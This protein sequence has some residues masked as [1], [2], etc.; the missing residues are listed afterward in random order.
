MNRL[1][2]LVLAFGLCSFLG[3]GMACL[4]P[5]NLPQERSQSDSEVCIPGVVFERKRPDFAGEACVS[6]FLNSVGKPTDQDYV[7]NQS[8]VNPIQ[9]RGCVA[10][11]LVQAIKN[12]GIETGPVSF[13]FNPQV[14]VNVWNQLPGE[15]KSNQPSIFCIRGDEGETFVLV[16]GIDPEQDSVVVMDPSSNEGDHRK[17]GREEFFR[18]SNID[19]QL[20]KIRL[21]V[22]RARVA[23]SAAGFTDADYAQHIR[24]L[25]TRLPG[26][27]FHILIQK[28]FVVIGDESPQRVRSRA[29]RTVKWAVEHIKQDYFSSDPTAII[30]IWL[31]KDK[32]SYEQNCRK[33]FR[34][35]PGTPFGFYS[36]AHRALVMNISTG[37]GTLVHEIVHPF[38]ESNFPECPSWFNEGLA[39]LYEQSGERNGQIIGRTNWRLRGLQLAIES[40]RLGSFEELCT[41]TR[42]EFYDDPNGTNYAQARYLC[43]YL[44][45]N[46]LLRKFYRQFLDSADQDP[47]G[48][49]TLQRVLGREDMDQFQR[50]WEAYVMK[51]RF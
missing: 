27:G 22:A 3:A 34:T 5:G 9:G 46:G 18:R 41:T 32:D 38:M 26:D 40:D 42:R 13:E 49:Q 50:E 31:F 30:D 28:P 2:N 14:L 20:I 15:I 45:E 39:S 1:A 23:P 43:Y 35:D 25:N 47:G 36:S 11:E 19:G 21:D 48:Y 44:Q 24:K 7:F 12:M 37:G 29:V 16:V 17:I 10:A 51:L 8:G 4:K 6:M 33:L